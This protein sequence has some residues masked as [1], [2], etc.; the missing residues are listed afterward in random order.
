MRA[1]R[2]ALEGVFGQ[3]S[4]MDERT[5]RKALTFLADF[6]SDIATD[7]SVRTKVLKDCIG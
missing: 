7:E 2:G 1:K 4:G 5:R 6:F 3:V